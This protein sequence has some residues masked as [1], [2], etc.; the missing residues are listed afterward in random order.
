MALHPLFT[1]FARV[2]THWVKGVLGW[3][4]GCIIST[5]EVS[6]VLKG[7]ASMW[8]QKEGQ[9]IITLDGWCFFHI[10]WGLWYFGLK[11]TLQDSINACWV[12]CSC[13]ECYV[14]HLFGKV[15]MLGVQP[16]ENQ[17]Y[18]GTMAELMTASD[19]LVV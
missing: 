2:T 12:L 14:F 1:S 6:I 19:P 17:G 3:R 15:V 9:G 18:L 8:H 11:S 4:G 7:F 16:T 5:L 13:M 10:T